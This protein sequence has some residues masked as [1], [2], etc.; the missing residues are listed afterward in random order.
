M[1]T[2]DP[3]DAKTHQIHLFVDGE[4]YETEKQLMT[5]DDIIREFGLKDPAT[6]Y[7]VQIGGPHGKVS[8]QGK[9][10]DPIVLQNGQKFQIISTGPTPVSDGPI[11]TG[12]EVFTE[13][14][15]GLGYV[16]TALPGK[17]DHLVFEYLVET[18]RFAGTAVQHGIIVPSDFPMTPPSG[19]HVSPH[20]HPI[21]TSGPHPTGS[22][23]HTHSQAFE[24]GAGGQWQYW[25]RP[26]LDWGQTKKTVAAYMSHI[27]RL[28]DS[29]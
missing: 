29:Q 24:E 19:P 5:P 21:N 7:L 2:N 28:W 13:G 16:P 6:N 18:G 9:G 8:Y 4:R 26:Y 23:H 27:W 1:N 25:S 14:L 15:R 11:P 22:V 12:F 10:S 3:K 17:P 20:I